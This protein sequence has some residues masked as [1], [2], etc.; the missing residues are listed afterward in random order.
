MIAFLGEQ[1]EA[2][3]GHKTALEIRERT[4][5]PWDEF[6]KF[7]FVRNPWDRFVSGYTYYVQS[8]SSVLSRFSFTQEHQKRTSI[9]GKQIAASGGF[10]DFCLNLDSYDL[11]LHFDP[12]VDYVT[13]TEGELIVDYVGR[14]ENLS[15]DLA[16]ICRRIGIPEIQLP[17]FRKTKRKHYREY[18]DEET[19]AVVRHKYARDIELFDYA[20]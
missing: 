7:C 20:F 2:N 17:H 11:D 18:Y 15:H 10:R 12:Q 6:F 13:D 3:Q 14:F 16:E 8:V 19:E 1:D 5:E 4:E 9:L